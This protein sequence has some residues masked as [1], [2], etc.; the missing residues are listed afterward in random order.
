MNTED[1]FYLSINNRSSSKYYPLNTSTNF[2]SKTPETLVFDFETCWY[3]G[4]TNF[5]HGK[6]DSARDIKYICVYL[7]F[8][9]DQMFG[10]KLEKIVFMAPFS[11]KEDFRHK[12]INIKY[13]K[14]EKASL[15][16]VRCTLTDENG[17]EIRFIDDSLTCIE[18]KFKKAI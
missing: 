9:S 10:D 14:I 8:I 12:I 17:E 7:D 11:K 4:V 15:V 2:V 5:S 6:I 3:V 16:D 1:F 18:L 13:C